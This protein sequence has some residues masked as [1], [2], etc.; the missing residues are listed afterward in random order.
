MSLSKLTSPSTVKPL[1]G[2]LCLLADGGSS[3]YLCHYL[4]SIGWYRVFL[5]TVFSVFL[6]LIYPL[7]I[8]D[9]HHPCLEY[10]RC[11]HL[12]STLSGIPS[13][14]VSRWI[15]TGDFYN[16]LFCSHVSGLTGISH[17]AFFLFGPQSVTVGVPGQLPSPIYC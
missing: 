1:T 7:L 14:S 15:V 17:C 12:V 9:L 3:V 13:P 5:P 4:L 11:H 6:L 2:L 10:H 8:L 16:S